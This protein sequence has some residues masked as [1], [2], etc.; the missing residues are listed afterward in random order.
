MCWPRWWSA[1]PGR[2]CRFW[3]P[4]I[5]IA[6]VPKIASDC[7][8]DTREQN[9]GQLA[10]AIETIKGVAMEKGMKSKTL[11]NLLNALAKHYAPTDGD[12]TPP[13]TRQPGGDTERPPGAGPSTGK[14]K[15]AK[16]KTEAVK[17]DGASTTTGGNGPPVTPRAPAAPAPAAA[18][19]AAASGPSTQSPPT[20][21][22]S[23]PYGLRTRRATADQNFIPPRSPPTAHET[24]VSP[25]AQGLPLAAAA[26]GPSP[27]TPI[28][29]PVPRSG[30]SPGALVTGMNRL[31]LDSE[32]KSSS[33][34]KVLRESNDLI[35]QKPSDIVDRT[36]RLLTTHS[37]LAINGA[38]KDDKVS[39]E[40]Y[41]KLKF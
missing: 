25:D 24:R 27:R 40:A 30:E 28:A 34:R 18:A 5:C 32:K 20:A 16:A 33:A 7:S 12:G 8:S 11:Q 6:R 38:S 4:E 23:R 37:R 36:Y 21:T 35:H 15:T 39:S 19:A 9:F 41:G 29:A 10:I 14:G 13:K 2:H 22:G 17:G 1:W 31:T 3:K 26:A